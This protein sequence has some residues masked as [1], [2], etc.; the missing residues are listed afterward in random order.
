MRF[1][2]QHVWPRFIY[3][4]SL[5]NAHRFLP[6][7]RGRVLPT[8]FLD[9]PPLPSLRAVRAEGAPDAFDTIMLALA[10]RHGDER[11]M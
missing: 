3:S 8:D 6:P 2:M 4:D 9:E 10:A 5:L 1:A 11:Q 7:H